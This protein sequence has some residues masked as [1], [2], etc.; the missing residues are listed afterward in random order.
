MIGI[1]MYTTIITLY[2]Q[3]KSQREISKITNVHRKTVKKIVSRYSKDNIE[4]PS[5]YHRQSKVEEWHTQIMSFLSKNLSV[6]RIF[7]EIKAQGFN[8]SYSALSR[9]IAKLY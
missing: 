7:E 8:S 4:N 5:N 3:G 2:K 6:V 1:A 9:Y